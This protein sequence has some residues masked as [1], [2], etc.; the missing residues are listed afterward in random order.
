MENR[1]HRKPKSIGGANEPP[2]TVIVP[3]NK[4]DAW[5][6][7]FGNMPAQKIFEEINTTWLDPD[8]KIEL[9]ETRRKIPY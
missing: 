9:V 3:K 8:Y 6:T 2:N 1:H 7:L 4:H 5:H